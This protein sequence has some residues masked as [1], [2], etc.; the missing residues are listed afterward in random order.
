MVDPEGDTAPT[1]SRPWPTWQPV[2]VAGRAVDRLRDPRRCTHG[3]CAV[4]GSG[5]RRALPS[6][7]R[8]GRRAS[9]TPT[10]TGRRFRVIGPDGSCARGCRWSVR[11]SGGDRRGHDPAR[12]RRLLLCIGRA[13][14][15]PGAAR[16]AGDRRRGRGA[17]GQL[18]GQG[19]RRATRRWARRRRGACARRRSWCGRGWRPTPRPARRCSRCSTTPRRSSRACRSTRRSSTSVGC[20]GSPARRRRSPRN[21]AATCASG[22]GSRHGRRRTDEVPGEGRE[23]GREARRPARRVRRRRARVPPPAP[24]RAAVGRRTRHRAEAPRALDHHGG[25]RGAAGR[26]RAGA[27][28]GARGGTAPARTGPQPRPAAGR[29]RTPAA[30]DRHAAGARATPA[31]PRDARH[32]P[33]RAGRP[34]R[35]A[36]ARRTASAERSRCACGSTTSRGRP[37]R[38]RSPRRRRHGDAAGDRA[39][40]ARRGPAR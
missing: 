22:S 35:P 19:L 20:G 28:P 36:L 31:L 3:V 14:R 13:A 38:T 2:L 1:L 11:A 23:P 7:S 10:S 9:S 6:R 15:R 4:R 32:R 5:R 26:G 12:R 16:P 40:P 18:R 37:G 25:G 30:L 29:G 27:D 39:D 17:G 21:C 33:A 34:S 8:R 24:G